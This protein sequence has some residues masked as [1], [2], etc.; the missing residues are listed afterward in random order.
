MI[1]DIL[2]APQEEK[3]KLSGQKPVSQKSGFNLKSLLKQSVALFN[4]ETLNRPIALNLEFGADIPS[5]IEGDPMHVRQILINLLGN[6]FK[7]TEQGVIALSAE[8]DYMTGL[9][10][11]A[12][13]DTGQGIELSRIN[14]IFEADKPEE[15]DSASQSAG[16]GLAISKQLAELLDGR[17]EVS[18]VVGQGS[19]FT[20]L[21]PVRQ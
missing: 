6:A 1:D 4:T 3:D 17:L 19:T 8:Y 20:L 5:V 13:S 16:K 10:T 18:S 9:L 2:D 14:E 15:S 21:I 11:V 7:F 12:V